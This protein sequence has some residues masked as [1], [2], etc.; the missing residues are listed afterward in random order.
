M[1]IFGDCILKFLPTLLAFFGAAYAVADQQE[2]PTPWLT[3]SLLSPA[4][5]VIPNGHYNYEP[6]LYVGTNFG[7]YNSHWGTKRANNLHTV[8]SQTIFEAGLPANFDFQIYPQFSWN[9]THGASSWDINDIPWGFDYQLLSSEGSQWWPKIKLSFFANLPVGKYQKLNPG[10]QRT[11]VG[12][13]GSWFPN[14]GIVFG[15]LFWF[16]G[17]HF[18]NVR[19]SADYTFPTSV[20]VKGYNT[21]GGGRHT[22]GRVFPGQFVTSIFAFEYTWTQRWAFAMDTVY[23]HYNKTRFK[24]HRGKT[25]GIPNQVGGPSSEVLSFAPAFEYNWSVNV[26]LI[27]GCWFTAAGRNTIRFANGVIAINIYK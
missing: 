8:I 9:H 18:L 4:G 26:G 13:S 21:Y 25:K 16:G 3:G 15:R 24:G 10:K 23:T 11:D 7:T 2:M 5:D 1:S 17:N 14:I 12:G 6:Y 19:A 27:A 20:H 22:R